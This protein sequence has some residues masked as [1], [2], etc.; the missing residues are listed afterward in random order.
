[1]QMIGWTLMAGLLLPFPVAFT[2]MLA[3]E[4]APAVHEV[5]MVQEGSAYR[6]VPAKLTVKQGDRVK[7]VMV[8][9]GPHNVAFDAEKIPDPAE[10]ALA[11][12]MPE[13]MSPLAGPLL[14]KPGESYTV[15]FANVAPGTYPFYCMPHMAMGMRGTVT[16]Q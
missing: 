1:M 13:T 11:A 14:T 3:P 8:S 15:S 10:R 5:R 7:F 2:R 6:F 16:V 9:G 12:G 4:P